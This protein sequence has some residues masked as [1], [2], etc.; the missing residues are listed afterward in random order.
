M[1]FQWERRFSKEN[2][3]KNRSSHI[4]PKGVVYKPYDS[5]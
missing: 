2:D 5:F 1:A 3:K 4:L